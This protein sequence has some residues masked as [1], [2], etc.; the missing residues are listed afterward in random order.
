M[1]TEK[2]VC[3][4]DPR[5]VGG[6]TQIPIMSIID[7]NGG[8][9]GIDYEYKTYVNGVI[10]I[11]IV[12]EGVARIDNDVEYHILV[13]VGVTQ[14]KNG[15]AVYDIDDLM[16]NMCHNVKLELKVEEKNSFGRYYGCDYIIKTDITFIKDDSP[17]MVVLDSGYDKIILC[18]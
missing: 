3:R 7:Y 6:T 9:V 16:L 11:N 5:D 1:H 14:D 8:G 13:I 12:L 18:Q 15:K 2:L 4:W 17:S 10:N